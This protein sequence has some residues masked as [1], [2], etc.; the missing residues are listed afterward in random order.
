MLPCYLKKPAKK[1]YIKN[2]SLMQK[3]KETSKCSFFSIEQMLDFFVQFKN[4]Y[5]DSFFCGHNHKQL[6]FE[7]ALKTFFIV[8]ERKSN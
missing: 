2:T 8:N 1:K 7:I 4:K 5:F 3:N 6:L